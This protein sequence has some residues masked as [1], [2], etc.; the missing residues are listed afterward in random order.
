M[1]PKIL[2]GN[3]IDLREKMADQFDS[4]QKEEAQKL[5]AEHKMDYFEVSAI[6]KI[7]VEEM[8]MALI[9]QVYDY[10]FTDKQSQPEPAN[11]ITIGP[12]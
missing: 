3:K 11:R 1:I 9:Q 10:K 6:E 7:G 5:A 8:M 2:V 12:S 4:I